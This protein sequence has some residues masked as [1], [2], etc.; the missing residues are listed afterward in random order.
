VRDDQTFVVVVEDHKAQQEVLSTAFQARGYQVHVAGTGAEALSIVDTTDPD[1]FVLDLG[2]PDIDGLVLCKHLR[3]RTPCPI[4]VVTADADERRVVEALDA[5]A[6]D[7]VTKPFSMS[8]LL[9]RSRVALRHRAS[10]AA[11]VDEQVLAAGDIQLDLSG[12]QLMVAGELVELGT[13]Q[14]ELL[15]IL[16]RNRDKVVTYAALDRA[17]GTN[18]AIDE[19]NPWRVSISKIRKQLGVGPQR[20]I[21]HTELRVGYRLVV[22][23]E[24]R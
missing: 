15:A 18:R 19:R 17:L 1:L 22:P 9:A 6:D 12:Y 13:R 24:P 8:V 11:V 20:P 23:D 21:V 14:F 5:G 10:A 4:I 16:V 7:Y 3:A 2:L